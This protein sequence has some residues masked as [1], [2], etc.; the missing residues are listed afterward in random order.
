[1]YAGDDTTD[2]DAFR[3]LRR[4]VQEGELESA[5]CVA[6]SSDEAPPE[7]AREADVNVDGTGAVRGL[8]E[9]LL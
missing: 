4:L 3:A 5:V 1:M 9:A 2:L 7:L 8:L 6:V